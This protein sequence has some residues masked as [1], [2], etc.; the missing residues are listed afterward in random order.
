[1]S[2]MR[3]DLAGSDVGAVG[4]KRME[5][6]PDKVDEAVMALLHLASFS[7]RGATRAWKGHD[8]EALNRLHGR[9]LILDPRSKAKSV[10]V[11]DQG[12]R[13]GREACEK[14]FSRTV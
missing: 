10:V 3:A 6:D 8:W 9:G 2:A 11:T 1:M 12:V 4:A 7:G 13:K 5:I 14:L